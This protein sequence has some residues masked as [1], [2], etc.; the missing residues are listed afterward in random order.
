MREGRREGVRWEERE[1]ERERGDMR[2][3]K[4]V[5]FYKNT[6]VVLEEGVRDR[7]DMIVTGTLIAHLT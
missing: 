5:S 4:G 2:E 3:E 6:N 1:R 7:R